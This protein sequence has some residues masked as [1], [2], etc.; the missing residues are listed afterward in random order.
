MKDCY[1]G[2]LLKNLIFHRQVG[3]IKKSHY[4][5]GVGGVPKKEGL[6]QF[7]DLRGERGSTSKMEV[8]F[9][10][11]SWYPN[12]CYCSHSLNIYY[13]P[14]LAFVCLECGYLLLDLWH[15]CLAVNFDNMLIRKN[16]SEKSFSGR[17]GGGRGKGFSTQH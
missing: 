3:G 15:A 6:G 11:G 17:R 7:A 9:L 4:K 5:G 16:L 12:A 14:C 13:A 2:G 10:R 1:F 8:E